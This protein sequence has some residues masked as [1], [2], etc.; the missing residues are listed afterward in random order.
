[1]IWNLLL[2]RNGYFNLPRLGSGQSQWRLL[3]TADNDRLIMSPLF[4]WLPEDL[5]GG[6]QPPS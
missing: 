1:M 5:V 3:G 2:V 4:L 6:G